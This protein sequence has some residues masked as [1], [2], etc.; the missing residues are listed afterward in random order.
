[1]VRVRLPLRR[2]AAAGDDD[3][4][5]ILRKTAF[6]VDRRRKVHQERH[7]AEDAL[8]VIDEADQLSQIG[9]RAQIE[10]SG[11]RRMLMFARADLHE[12]Y[13]SGEAI[14]DALEALHGP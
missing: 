2:L 3:A 6:H 13:L 10:H 14:D 1:M 8:G 4:G 11:E 9:L 12:R 5:T 7:R